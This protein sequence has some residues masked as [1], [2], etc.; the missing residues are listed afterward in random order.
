MVRHFG[1]ELRFTNLYYHIF[2]QQKSILEGGLKQTYFA[3]VSLYSGYSCQHKCQGINSA[4]VPV[5]T[6]PLFILRQSEHIAIASMCRSINCQS[7][8]SSLVPSY[9]PA[10]FKL[11]LPKFTV[12]GKVQVAE[13]QENTLFEPSQYLR[14]SDLVVISFDD[15]S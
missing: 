9:T 14:I 13:V 11:Q 15:S 2:L 12:E 10:L 8:N 5:Y 3:A 4:L 1:S 7:I 6:P